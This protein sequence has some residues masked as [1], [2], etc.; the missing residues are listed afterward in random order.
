M[1]EQTAVNREVV[2]SNPTWRGINY[3]YI[4]FFIKFMSKTRIISDQVFCLKQINWKKLYKTVM[5]IQNRIVKNTE[6][7]QFRQIRD[8]QRLLIKSY[9]AKLIVSQKIIE[10]KYTKQY[11]IY[12]KVQDQLL[13]K[14]NIIDFMKSIDLENIDISSSSYSLYFQLM[15][16]LWILVLLPV[17]ETNS[18]KLSYNCRLYRTH[19]DFIPH[20]LRI[21]NKINANWI[22]STRIDHFFNDKNVS[23][24]SRNV[25]IEKKFLLF[26]LKSDL[27]FASHQKA[28][29]SSK[30]RFFQQSLSLYKILQSFSIQGVTDHLSNYL[31]ENP[32]VWNFS[33]NLTQ[34]PI[35]LYNNFL[36]LPA[37]HFNQFYNF[38][39]LFQILYEVRGLKIQKRWSWVSNLNKGFNFLG[40]SFKKRYDKVIIHINRYNIKAH[41]FEIKRL[42]K[43]TGHQPMDKVIDRLNEKIIYW[44]YYYSGAFNS[45]QIWLEMN[46]Y[47]FWR[48][49][50]WCKKRHKNKGS[51]WIYERYW[52]K[53]NTR[54]W[55]FSVNG[56]SLASYYIVS[57]SA[58][59]NIFKTK[60]YKTVYNVQIRKK[61]FLNN[62]IFTNI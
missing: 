19:H 58:S 24:L 59:V 43:L 9:S 51:K 20:F 36:I 12:K 1:V 55:V 56:H 45:Y 7:K 10:K 30:K 48:I 23:W 61:L 44:Q 8:L 40:W 22:F 42:L 26:Y 15:Y 21:C 38:R 28:Y 47:L 57:L 33:S 34:I 29:K 46:S 18:E 2:G 5:N 27:F 25:L 17:L 13:T 41:K 16:L 50:K 62:K 52:I 53:Q 37:T 32:L 35:F 14:Y 11:M 6:K 3:I 60:N 54:N 31:D 49:W 39:K 4:F